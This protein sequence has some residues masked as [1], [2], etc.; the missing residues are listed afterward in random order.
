MDTCRPGY[1]G[2]GF[3]AVLGVIAFSIVV[4]GLGVVGAMVFMAIWSYPL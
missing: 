2:S 3:T 1:F 4:W